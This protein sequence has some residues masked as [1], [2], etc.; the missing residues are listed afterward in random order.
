M[1]NICR[2]QSG[3]YFTNRTK[4]PST[5]SRSLTLFLSALIVLIMEGVFYE[6]VIDGN[7]DCGG[8]GYRWMCTQC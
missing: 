2:R 6:I 8:Y 4:Q 1:G 7:I 5:I 3:N